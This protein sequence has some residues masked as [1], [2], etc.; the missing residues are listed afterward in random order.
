MWIT[1]QVGSLKES[2]VCPLEL[3]A[4]GQTIGRLGKTLG[5][6]RQG[7]VG[8]KDEPAGMRLRDRGRLFAAAAVSKEARRSSV[9]TVQIDLPLEH[10]SGRRKAKLIGTR[11]RGDAGGL[12]CRTASGHVGPHKTEIAKLYG[13]RARGQARRP[14]R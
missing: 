9:Q 8:A 6:E 2:H 11:S 14:C 5:S 10:W 13:Q 3:R 12:E 7:L 1:I 4:R